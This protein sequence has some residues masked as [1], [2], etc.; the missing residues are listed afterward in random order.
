MSF[1][2]EHIPWNK[3]KMGLVKMSVET[4]RKMSISNKKAHPP[5]FSTPA[6]RLRNYRKNNSDRV[7]KWRRKSDLLRKGVKIDDWQDVLWEYGRI[8]LRCGEER[9]ISLDHIIPVSIKKIEKYD[10]Y[11]PLCMRCNSWK[12]NRV[13]IDYRKNFMSYTEQLKLLKII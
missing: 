9:K 8:C 4:R 11:Q 13:I 10:N 2:K 1:K 12:G 7:K 3:G 5:M 6:E